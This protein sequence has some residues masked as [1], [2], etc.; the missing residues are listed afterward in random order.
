MQLFGNTVL[1]EGMRRDGPSTPPTH[2]LRLPW[3]DFNQKYVY[4]TRFIH[5]SY[6][7]VMENS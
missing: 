5:F 2:S 7:P 1:L 3:N 6:V 4:F